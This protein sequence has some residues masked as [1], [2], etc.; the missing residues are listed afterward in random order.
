MQGAAIATALAHKATARALEVDD[1]VDHKAFVARI[2]AVGAPWPYL[3]QP[4]VPVG[5]SLAFCSLV[6]T[7]GA[8]YV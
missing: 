8:S 4:R 7:R 5:C 2:T 3:C 6:V 1:E